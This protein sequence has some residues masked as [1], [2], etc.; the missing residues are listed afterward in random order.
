MPLF[1]KKDKDIVVSDSYNEESNTIKQ[2]SYLLPGI[3]VTTLFFLWGFSYGLLDTLNKH[4]KNVLG[5]STT[6][7]TYMQVAYFGAYFIFSIPASMISKR[8]GY[9]K[10]I[11]F[12]LSLYVIGALCFYPSATNLSFGGFVGSLFVIACGIATLENCANTYIT[13]IGSRK[14]ASLRINTAQ[15]FNGLASTIAPVIASYAFFGGDESDTSANTLDSV[16]WTYIGVACGVFVIGVIFCFARIPEVDEEAF[17]AA[18]AAET[19][20]VVRRASLLSPH[21]LLGS[22]TQF[23]YTGAQVAVA[24]MFMFYAS[25]VG[26]FPD[27]RGSILLSAGQGCFT[28]G[29]FIGAGLM[30]RYR[31]DYLMI[32][33]SIGAIISNIFVISMKTESTTYAL[34]AVMFFESILFPTIFSLGTRDL[35]RNHKRGSAFIIAGVSGGAVLPPIQAVIHDNVNVNVSFV[36]PLIAFV[37]VL[38]YGLVGHRWV[39]YI[40]DPIVNSQ[41]EIETEKAD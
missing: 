28:I 34:L 7:T 11:I 40:D 39:R 36:I 29:R 21:L 25:D 33:F 32:F 18:E 9:K 16:K 41:N 12:G 4:F 17:M 38:A 22:F 13:I 27:S 14:H 3:L 37:V 19:G 8:F 1:K 15:A 30:S 31:A 26:H 35:G 5:I 2:P 20:E 23:M 10:A 6:E 24:S